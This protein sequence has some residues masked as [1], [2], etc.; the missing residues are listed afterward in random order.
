MNKMRF[1]NLLTAA[2]ML[3]VAF[4]CSKEES[5]VVLPSNP[6]LVGAMVKVPAGR[7]VRGSA[8]GM[9]IER[10]VDTITLTKPFLLG[11]VEV[12][13]SEFCKFLNETAVSSSGKIGST[14]LLA[15]SDTSRG[16]RFNYGMVHNGAAWQP[17]SEEYKYYPAIYVTWY[18]ASAYCRWAGG[19]LPTEAE[20]EWAAGYAGLKMKTNP[21]VDSTFRYAGTNTF[22]SLGSYAWTNANSGGIPKNV[23]TKQPNILGLYDMMGNVNEWCADWFGNTYYQLCS[24]SASMMARDSSKNTSG[25]EYDEFRKK[26]K[27]LV[28]PKGSDSVKVKDYDIYFPRTARGV[29][30]K[31]ARKVFRGGS[32]VEVQTSGTEGTHRVSYRGHMLPYMTWNSYGF[33][34]AK[35]L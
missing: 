11:A 30:V 25:Y 9:D 28:D 26:A 5:E 20:W 21:Q 15:A 29:G 27:W 12:T 32:Y 24:D 6:A 31:G 3:G 34:M 33:R 23:G 4:A 8:A 10:P 13:N 17:V 16:G 1:K 7:F 18:G 19:R 14:T 22:A 35:D 2:L